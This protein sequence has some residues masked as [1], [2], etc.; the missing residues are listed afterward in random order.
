MTIKAT[1]IADSTLM[2]YLTGGVYNMADLGRLGLNRQQTPGAFNSLT[3]L[4]KPCLVIH[5]RAVTP[6]GGIADPTQGYMSVRQV[7]ELYF[8]ND[9]DAGYTT[10]TAA[11]DR[12]YALLHD[13]Q[14]DG[15]VVRLINRMPELREANLQQAA[16]LRDDY[17]LI[18]LLSA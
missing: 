12:V 1:L 7:A 17:Q 11:R 14:V 3:G 13:K 15:A 4:M 5:F 6:F 10:L 2:T 16:L 9:G 18:G 8:Y